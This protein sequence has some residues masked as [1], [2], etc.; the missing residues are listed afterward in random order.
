MRL[1]GRMEKKA[2]QLYPERAKARSILLRAFA[3]FLLRS[4]GLSAGRADGDLAVAVWMDFHWPVPIRALCAGSFGNLLVTG[5]IP[6]NEQI[7]AWLVF[8]LSAPLAH[9]AL[10]LL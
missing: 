9:H 6:G 3:P 5:A 10:L 2:C 7:R 8:N 4:P 1:L